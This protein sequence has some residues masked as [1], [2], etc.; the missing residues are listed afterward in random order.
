MQGIQLHASNKKR[1]STALAKAVWKAVL[2][3]SFSDAIKNE[4]NWRKHYPIY[5]VASNLRAMTSKETALETASTGLAALYQQLQFVRGDQA[6]SIDDAMNTPKPDHFQTATIQGQEHFEAL[7]VPFKGELLSG[8]ALNHQL[9]DWFEKEYMDDAFFDALNRVAQDEQA[10]DLRG[11]TFVLLGAGSEVGPCD[12]LLARGA[13]VV[14]VD[15]PRPDIMKRLID[16]AIKSPGQLV[17]PV[18]GAVTGDEMPE[19]LAQ[20]AGADLLTDTPEIADWLLKLE[21]GFT[22]GN[23]AY[24]DGFQHLR[25]SVAMDAI[26]N[27]VISQRA[28]VA[29]SYLMTPSDVYCVPSAIAQCSQARFQHDNLLAKL[30]RLL[31]FG[32]L[33]KPNISQV[34]Q[35]KWGVINALVVEQGPNYNLAKRLQRW[36]A[37]LA[38]A[39]GVRVSCNVAPIN[40]TRSVAKRKLFAAGFSGAENFG[41]KVF[42]PVTANALLGLCLIDDLTSEQSVANPTAD[43]PSP[44]A[45][46]ATSAFHGGL[47][48]M[49]YQ[50]QSILIPGVLI[51]FVKRSFGHQFE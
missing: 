27:R 50:L 25:V 21:D 42:K 26:V 2:P 23:Y 48:K 9:K 31:S 3:E 43:L 6:L 32:A 4:R 20:M 49:A 5:V 13:R 40:A 45:L 47:W 33:F 35:S 17:L 15:L 16:K 51:G 36:R 46:F 22:L 19:Q 18:A 38:R 39:Q 28:D 34:L 14:A 29:L 11:Q 24:L 30:L 8:N 44:E 37:V 12:F 1:S 10:S 7:S 41:I